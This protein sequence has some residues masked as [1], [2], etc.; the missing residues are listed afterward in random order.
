MATLNLYKASKS[1][2]AKKVLEDVSIDLKTGDILGIFGRNGCGKST[3]LKMLFG[4]LKADT[5]NL[6]INGERITSEAI[7]PGKIIAY[8]PQDPFIPKN[9]K[10]RD[11]IPMYYKSQKEQDAVFYN[12]GVAKISAKKVG[13]LSLGERRY[14]EVILI[15]NLPHPFIMLDEPFSMIDPLHKEAIKTFLLTLKKTKGIILTDHYY[16]DVLEITTRNMVI[17]EGKSTEIAS[18]ESLIAL[19]YLSKRQL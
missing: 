18:K 17:S 9:V 4:T 1:F 12:P 10:V 13:S 11:V 5:L 15:G 19:K 3:L 6:K 8:L 14:F 16:D 7:I 2:G